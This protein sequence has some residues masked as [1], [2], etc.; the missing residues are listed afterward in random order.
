MESYSLKQLITIARSL[1]I[2]TLAARV[3]Y[4]LRS[5]MYRARW[6]SS[7]RPRG[8]RVAEEEPLGD[9]VAYGV[10]GRAVHLT[11]SN[12]VLHLEV[13]DAGQIRVALRRLLPAGAGIPDPPFS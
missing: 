1:G 5:R 8:S 4:A 6:P 13:L 2:R 9:L 12:G 7:A 3:G 11:C 10:D